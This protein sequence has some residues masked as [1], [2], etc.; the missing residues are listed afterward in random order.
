MKTFEAAVSALNFND[1]VNFK[2]VI[3][4]S[5]LEYACDVLRTTNDPHAALDDVIKLANRF[6]Y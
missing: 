6:S 3:L 1:E 5:Y 4:L 2:S